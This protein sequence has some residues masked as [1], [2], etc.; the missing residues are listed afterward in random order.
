MVCTKKMR[1]RNKANIGEE[2]V[3]ISKSVSVPLGNFDFVVE[4]FKPAGVDMEFCMSDQT[5]KSFDLLA[6]ELHESRNTA[7]N[8]SIKPFKPSFTCFICI[9]DL[10]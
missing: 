10:K 8:G 4:T 2:E 3:Q 6:S 9:G 7:V 5:V 1:N